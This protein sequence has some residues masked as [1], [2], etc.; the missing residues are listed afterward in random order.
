MKCP[1]CNI[2]IHLELEVQKAFQIEQLIEKETG[3]ELAQGFCPECKRPI[4]L[5]RY[6][7]YKWVDNEGEITNVLREEIIYPKFFARSIDPNVPPKYQDAYN[8]ANSVLMLS[9]KA[10]AALSRRLLQNILWDE[11]HLKRRN[12]DT[13]ITE[14]IQLPNTPAEITEALDAIRNIGNF[15]A[16]PIKYT[17]TGEIVEVEPGEAEWLL[18]VL[19][20]LFDFVFVQP[21]RAR[22]RI[23]KL[24]QKLHSLGKPPIKS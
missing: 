24:N 16:H 15:A 13:E 7:Q 5:M 14:F 21:G 12:L 4:V 10:S 6:G 9:P 22:E 2:G 11:Y 8:E 1:H 3:Y 17:N 19:E 20:A 23:D 18:E